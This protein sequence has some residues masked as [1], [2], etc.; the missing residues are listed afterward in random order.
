MASAHTSRQTRHVRDSRSHKPAIPA[1]EAPQWAA[2]RAA[3]QSEAGRA[4]VLSEYIEQLARRGEDEADIPDAYFAAVGSMARE[5][6][7]IAE[8]IQHAGEVQR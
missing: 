3:I 2:A 6:T 1:G 4:G 5:I 7:A 8:G